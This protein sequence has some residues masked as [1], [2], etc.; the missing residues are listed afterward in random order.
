VC[1]CDCAF[2]NLSCIDDLELWL[3]LVRGGLGVKN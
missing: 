2:I 3:A 1:V